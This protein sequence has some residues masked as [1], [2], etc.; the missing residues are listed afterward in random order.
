MNILDTFLWVILSIIYRRPVGR[1][2]FYG[3]L[4]PNPWQEPPLWEP[5][6]S[7]AGR[8]SGRTPSEPDATR[9]A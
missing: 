4:P 2:G 3:P 5:P 1:Y 7:R 8:P 9:P 6:P